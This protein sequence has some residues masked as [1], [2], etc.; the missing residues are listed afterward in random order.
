[1]D[2]HYTEHQNRYRSCTL[3][4]RGCRRD[5]LSQETGF[6][7][8][9]DELRIASAVLHFGEEPPVTG[10]GGSGTIFVTGCTLQCVFCQNVQ[11]SQAG[12]GRP[13]SADEFS[14]ISLRLQELGAENINIVTGSH[15]A[16]AIAGALERAKGMGLSIPVLWN[17]SAYETVEALD[18]LVGLV[19]GWLP[20][21]KTLNPS[22]SRK[23][24]NA[25]DYPEA[26][27]AGILRMAELCPLVIEN[28]LLKS[29]VIMR[30][31]ALPG[32]I[33]DTRDV[34]EW[35][36]RN[37]K[38]RALLSLMTQ[39]TPVGTP[40]ENSGIEYRYINDAEFDRMQR[41]LEEFGIEDGFY[42]ELAEDSSWL[43]D[44]NNTCP[45]PSAL[46]RPVWHW[47]TGLSME[48]V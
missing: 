29:G 31:L 44:F 34:L 25:P 47:K 42:Q 28:G 26:A 8:E 6:C 23:A 4:P 37:L 11:I 35:F 38:G 10:E 32:R 22:V 46:A 18:L 14:A 7:G 2:K 16:P 36:S 12:M 33:E 45:F 48:R 17:S 40:P 1:M 24:F 41:L 27:A 19:D 30:H 21:L 15:A 9:T 39:F 20:D 3:C 13:V 5:R 43:P